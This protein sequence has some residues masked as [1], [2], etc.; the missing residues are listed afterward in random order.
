MEMDTAFHMFAVAFA[1]IF[2]ISIASAQ[3][4]LPVTVY[5]NVT[6]ANGTRVPDGWNVTLINTDT[7]ESWSTTT[8]EGVGIPPIYNYEIVGTAYGTQ[9]FRVEARDP[10]GTYYGSESF[11]ASGFED[12]VVDIVVRGAPR[13]EVIY[14][15]G[16]ETIKIGDVVEVSARAIG[17]YNITSVEFSYYNGTAW[18]PIG[19]GV[20]VNGSLTDGIWNASWDTLGLPEGIKYQI[21]ANATDEGGNT[22]S[23]T[24]GAFTLA[25]LTPPLMRNASAVPSKVMVNETTNITFYVDIA[26]RDTDVGVVA[27][28]MDPGPGTSWKA[29]T[30]VGSYSA[31]NLTWNIY[32]YET[33]INLT[34]EGTYNYTVAAFDKAGNKNTTIITVEAIST[35]TYSIS[36]YEGWNLIS[37]PLMPEDTSIDAVIPN[38]SDG[39]MIF[40]DIAGPGITWKSAMYIEG[41]GWYGDL[42]ELVPKEGYLYMANSNITINVTGKE[43]TDTNTTIY[44]GWNLIGYAKD[45]S[46]PLGDAIGAEYNPANDMIFGD[47]AGP[48]ISWKS[49]MYIEGVGWDGELYELTPEEGYFYYRTGEDFR[50]TIAGKVLT[51]ISTPVYEGWNLLGYASVTSESMDVINE[52]YA[53]DM[54]F[55]DEAGPGI[56]WKSAMYIEGVGWYGELSELV[57]GEGYFYY[58]EG[59]VFNWTYTDI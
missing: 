52:P 1:L 38:P 34:A 49:A 53:G 12:K 56:T 18:N 15:S 11:T 26:D 33:V 55:G 31:D 13:I 27:I 9:N 10:T 14:P 47:E 8:E 22:A 45:V 48:G 3:V 54:I 25:D 19:A 24:S 2:A 36:I 46:M 16:G 42:S 35:K 39:D 30:F 17:D 43:V 44:N 5:G 23:N 58:R 59:N 40:G 32:K 37:L 20:L 51:N 29:M 28:D 6:Y 57:P 7:G 21:M 50:L 41:V 4:P